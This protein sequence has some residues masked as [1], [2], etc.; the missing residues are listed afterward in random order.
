[1]RAVACQH[2]EFELVE[3]PG[4]R[5]RSRSG[6]DRGHPLR[7]LRLGPA[8][9][10]WDRPAGRRG[11]R[12]RLRPLR[13]LRSAGRLRARVQRQGRRVRAEVPGELA[14]GA[15]VVALPILR[16]ENGA[17]ATGLSQH[18]PGAYAEQLLVQESMMMPVP[19]G[20][21][22]D[23]RGAYRADGRRLARRSPR[24]GRQARRGDRGRLRPDRPRRDPDAEGDR[25][26]HRRRQRL[27]ARPTGARRALRSRLRR[28]PLGRTPPTSRTEI[29]AGCQAHP[30][31]SSSRSTRARSS[32]VCPSA[33]GMPGGWRRSSAPP[34]SGP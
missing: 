23:R 12:G 27:L 26:P 16:G 10:P 19:N 25:R 20:L 32:A 14:A 15:P 5:A 24:G 2:G 28:R 18:A 34:R 13:A 21:D 22:P 7:D 29:P 4:A 30:R 17:D 11:A 9:S 33:G 31:R 8:R 1:M 3:R 6:A